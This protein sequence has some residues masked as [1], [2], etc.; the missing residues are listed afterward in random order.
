MFDPE[1]LRTFVTGVSMGNFARAAD[2]LGRSTSAVSAQMR[3]LEQ[4][5]GTTLL[6]KNGR[7]LALT[8]E[9]RRFLKY[10]NRIVDLHEEAAL[11]MKDITMRGAVRIGMQEDLA[12]EVMP[13]VLNCFMSAHPD[14]YFDAAVSD[15]EDLMER[16]R[17]DRLDMII[18]WDFNNA[19][20]PA[21]KERIASVPLRW[22]RSS[23]DARQQAAV[24]DG[25]NL[26][27]SEE[28]SLSLILMHEPCPLRKIALDTLEQSGRTFRQSFSCSG[29][30]AVWAAVRAGVGIT[31]RPDVFLPEGIRAMTPGEMGLPE[32]HSVALSLY[33]NTRAKNAIYRDFGTLLM[34]AVTSSLQGR[35]DA[36]P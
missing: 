27:P 6:K 36:R 35:L 32:M 10:A 12:I 9:G 33:G 4:Q 34:S 30:S 11:A 15:S 7:G 13:S 31:L 17:E 26:L 24:M 20:L 25:E 14:V 3:K 22:L 2:K 8:E 23:N 5:A 29:L 21:A 1:V 18:V 16:L 19:Q 28:E